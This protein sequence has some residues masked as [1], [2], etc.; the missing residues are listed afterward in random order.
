MSAVR[1]TRLPTLGPERAPLAFSD[2]G[3]DAT[4]HDNYGSYEL[5]MGADAAVLL[6]GERAWI[7]KEVDAPLLGWEVYA[8]KKQVGGEPGTTAQIEA[9]PAPR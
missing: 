6:R 3:K 4:H 7:F 8:R 1:A 5:A 9:A 2:G